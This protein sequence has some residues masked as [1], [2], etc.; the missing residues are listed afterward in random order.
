MA[1][2][3]QD[4][5]LTFTTTFGLARNTDTTQSLFVLRQ[6]Q[7]MRLTLLLL[8]ISLSLEGLTQDKKM[9]IKFSPLSSI[10]FVN[11][12]TLQ[13]GVE[14][15]LSEKMSWY[16]ELGLRY[17]NGS[18]EHAD[19]SFISAKGLKAKTELR[20]YLKGKKETRSLKRLQGYYLAAAIFY[21]LDHH[22]A[23]AN[24]YFHNDTA[25]R[26]ADNFGVKKTVWGV[27]FLVGNQQS[28]GKNFLIDFYAGLGVRYRKI[29][30]T[31][32]E[33]EDKQD[34][35]IEPIDVTIAGIK[36]KAE[37]KD[38]KTVLP[39]LTFGFRLCYTF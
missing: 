29:S 24:Y 26:R 19:T 33:F 1:N 39:N 31:N 15:S 22:N 36:N 30:T 13:G 9:A 3:R 7:T 12:P 8:S 27:N 25:E 6:F 4:F 5:Q 38:G 14:F 16:N 37:S 11:F 20:Y 28:F 21:V 23:S 17:T 35:L 34:K 10:D 2:R 18:Y 32:K